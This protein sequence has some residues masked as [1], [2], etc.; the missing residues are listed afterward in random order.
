MHTSR[1]VIVGLLAIT[2]LQGT[3]GCTPAPASGNGT[4]PLSQISGAREIQV[5]LSAAH[6]TTSWGD[7]VPG[8]PRFDLPLLY[9]HRQREATAEADRTLAISLS[10]LAA[11]TEIEMEVVSRHVDGSTGNQHS[12]TRTFVLPD[13][14]CT[15]DDPCTV[16]WTF[17]PTAMLSDFYTL[18][19]KDDVGHPLWEN[20]YPDRPDVVMLDTWDVGLGDYTVRVYYATLFPFPFARL[21]NELGNRLPP[22][23]VTDFIEHRLVPVIVDTWNTHFHTWG[24]APIHPDWDPDKVVE[25]VITDPPFALFE[26]TGTYTHFVRAD[27]RL[28]RERRIWWFSTNRSFEAYD[29]LKSGCRAVFAHEFFHLAQWNTL[30][31]T[32]RPTNFWLGVFIEAQASFAPSVQH[33]KM[34]IGQDHLV[35]EDSSYSSAANSFLALRLNTSYRDLDADRNSMYDA[36]LYW[37]FLYEQFNDIGIIRAALEEMTVHFEPDIVASMGSVMNSAFRRFDGPFRSFEDSLIAF[38]R[39]N[40]ALRLENGR[41]TAADLAECDGFYYDPNNVYVDPP[42]EAELDYDGALLTYDGSIPASF[43]MDFVEVSLDPAVHNQPVT[44]TFQGE[45]TVAQFNV[46]I[47]KLGPGGAKPRAVTPHPETIPQNRGDVHTYFIPHLDTT[48]YDR[49]AF[50]ITRLD[51]DETTDP[52]GNYHITL[53]AASDTDDDSTTK[54]VECLGASLCPDTDDDGKLDDLDRNS[55]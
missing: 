51:S 55:D 31:S 15:S 36:A 10:G 13:H 23:A 28:Y 30:L 50:L 54:Q 34:E 7:R 21:Q 43:G 19:V 24:F 35:R 11:G 49:L 2:L 1:S 20:P 8:Q 38:T 9:L 17:D 14:P 39:A 27:G 44:V 40:Y 41:C 32:G 46:Q 12:E 3:S 37:R 26:G 25:I 53:E 29:S 42:L 4:L 45:G 48:T 52:A 5:T 16:Q 22:G 6:T 47:W 18:R 33:P